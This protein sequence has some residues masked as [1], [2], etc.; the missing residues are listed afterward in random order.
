MPQ[1]YE[2]DKMPFEQMND[3]VFRRYVYGEHL[4]LCYFKILKG[5]VVPEH[6][7]VNEQLTYIVKGKVRVHS[8]GKEFIVSAGEVILFP[9]NL[10]HRF[11]AL[12]DTIDIDTFS[13]P[14]K[15]WIEGTANY[16]TKK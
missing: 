12:E 13:P 8:G 1:F 7:H 16:F 5:G 15:D 9:S 4:M 3:K 11:E 14:R 2:F 6:H 10:P